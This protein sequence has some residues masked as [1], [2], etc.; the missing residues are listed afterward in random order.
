MKG[1]EVLK[2]LKETVVEKDEE[3]DRL[4]NVVKSTHAVISK[5]KIEKEKKVDNVEK[6]NQGCQNI[7]KELKEMAKKY[8][9][10]NNEFERKNKQ[11]DPYSLLD[12]RMQ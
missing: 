2:D 1:F 7:T 9:K 10:E 6:T 4:K 12:L 3:I 11:E 5:I 8:K